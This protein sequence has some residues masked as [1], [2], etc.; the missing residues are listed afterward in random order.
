MYKIPFY[1]DIKTTLRT[2]PIFTDTT[3]V[4]HCTVDSKT[5]YL[6][7]QVESKGSPSVKWVFPVHETFGRETSPSCFFSL[8]RYLRLY[9]LVLSTVSFIFSYVKKSLFMIIVRKK[10]YKR[11]LSIRKKRYVFHLELILETFLFL[12]RR[13]LLSS[14]VVVYGVLLLWG[15]VL[16]KLILSTSVCL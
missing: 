2:I 13:L 11:S 3:N 6:K 10:F 4:L 14:Y 16:S 15:R 8:I 7:T 12:K 5:T 1:N 9:P